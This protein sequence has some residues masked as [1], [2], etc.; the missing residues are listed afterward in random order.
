MAWVCVPCVLLQV[1]GKSGH[2]KAWACESF[3]RG[4]R[5]VGN[6]AEE[7]SVSR[8]KSSQA[9]RKKEAGGE[10]GEDAVGLEEHERHVLIFGVGA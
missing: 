2:H 4:E 1:S 6:V 3:G 8:V 9:H 5:G 7:E 10:G